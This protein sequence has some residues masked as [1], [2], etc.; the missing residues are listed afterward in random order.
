MILVD[1]SVWVG[2]FRLTDRHLVRLLGGE[3]VMT[4]PFVVGELACGRMRGRAETLSLLKAL[5]RSTVAY[6]DEVLLFIER[7]ALMGAGIGYVDVH[8]LASTA[9]SPSCRIWT[10]DR[11]L[12]AA[13]T[14][15]DLEY[16]APDL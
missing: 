3:L 8:L 14:L 9:L 11:R 15:L 7:H 4:H 2:H 12:K 6:D 1:T 16:I 5:P 13:A 10:H